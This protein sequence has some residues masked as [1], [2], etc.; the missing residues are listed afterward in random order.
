MGT[1]N[2]NLEKRF[3]VSCNLYIY[4]YIRTSENLVTAAW[5]RLVARVIELKCFEFIEF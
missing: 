2:S 5:T 4:I 3:V 1:G